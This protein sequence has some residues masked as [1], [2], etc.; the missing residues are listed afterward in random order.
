MYM[1][2]L[3]IDFG[4][5]R[6]GLSVG[7]DKDAIAFPREVIA[8]DRERISIIK[9]YIED[10]NIEV[11]VMGESNNLD[12]TPNPI[13]KA[14]KVFAEEIKD[15]LN[16]PVFYEPETYTSHQAQHIQG[17][18]KMIDASAASLILNSFFDRM[19]HEKGESDTHADIYDS[20]DNI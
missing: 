5:K 16:I 4:G 9:K 1:N 2:Y 12:G 3:G 7:N 6:I 10:E 17:K 19:K 20:I 15:E 18:N 14:I 13:M 11:V 8:N